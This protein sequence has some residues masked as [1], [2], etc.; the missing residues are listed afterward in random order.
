MRLRDLIK[1][2]GGSLAFWPFAARAQQAGHHD[3]TALGVGV[4]IPFGSLD[5]P[6]T[7]AAALRS[8]LG[9][10]I[11]VSFFGVSNAQPSFRRVIE[12]LESGVVGG[13]LF[14][15]NNIQSKRDLE[16]MVRDI[17]LCK[18]RTVPL[19]A[20]DEEGG[21][22]DRLGPR[23]GFPYVPAAMEVGRGDEEIANKVYERLAQKLF[24]FG[25][26]MNLAPVVDL[27]I[28]AWNPVIGAQG[29]SFSRDP[30]IVSRL[31]KTFVEEHR[32]KGILTSLKHFPGHGSSVTDSHFVVP[33]VQTSWSQSELAPY[34]YLIGAGA[35]DTIM[36]GHL[37]NPPKW[38]G[39]ATQDG[40]TAITKLLRE[41]LRFDGVV[42]SDD[43]SMHA[44]RA[45]TSSFTDAIRSAA[46]AGIDL[47]LVTGDYSD[48]SGTSTGRYVNS[49]L[50][51][52][53]NSGQIALSSIEKS[54][55]RIAALKSRLPATW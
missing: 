47:I 41:E 13:V 31:A 15:Y 23:F 38:G 50:L 8:T 52:G 4:D 32:K 29:R 22:S 51:E 12:D 14:L 2:I 33:N 34:E 17:R 35:V 40:S 27:N 36:V 3:T 9:Q 39:V 30:A 11:I 53:V 1:V 24:D 42:M 19:I 7:D 43:L 55:Q 54:V 25:F 10:M 46:K 37:A 44:I 49:A 18:C 5:L 20:I 21:A 28:N 48:F 26:N 45:R 16:S 6:P